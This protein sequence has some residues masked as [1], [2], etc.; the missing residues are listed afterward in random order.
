STMRAKKIKTS[1]SREESSVSIMLCRI[2]NGDMR[3][4][5]KGYGP[6]RGISII[7][8]PKARK[9]LRAFGR[10]NLSKKPHMD[11]NI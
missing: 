2:L 5:D 9:R 4:S 1:P 6:L 3:Q 11:Q 7:I 8:C 10:R